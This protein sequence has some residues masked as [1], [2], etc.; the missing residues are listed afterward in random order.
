MEGLSWKLLGLRGCEVRGSLASQTNCGIIGRLGESMEKRDASAVQED[1]LEAIV[2][3]EQEQGR[4]RVRDLSER[5][6]VHKSTVTAALKVLT[7]KGF[8]TYEPYGRIAMT[9]VGRAT[10]E[11]V[12]QRH[13]LLKSFLRDILLVEL[14]VAEENA[15]RMEHVIDAGVLDRLELFAHFMRDGNQ[16]GVQCMEAFR[17]YLTG[18]DS[19]KAATRSDVVSR[20]RNH[21]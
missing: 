15:C 5:L 6:A 18:V 2:A 9:S 20:G 16:N 12:L 3:L 8:I 10:A 13:R 11:R 7:D 17:R 19:V 14:D 4:V 21:R 1:Y